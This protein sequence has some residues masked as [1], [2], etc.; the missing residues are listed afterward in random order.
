MLLFFYPQKTATISRKCW[1]YLAVGRSVQ[2]EFENQR[3]SSYQVNIVWKICKSAEFWNLQRN[4]YVFFRNKIPVAFYLI[5]SVSIRFAIHPS[6]FER[7]KNYRA[8]M[9]AMDNLGP[10]EFWSSDRLL[11][12]RNC[13]VSFF[14]KIHGVVLTIVLIFS[15]WCVCGLLF[16][17]CWKKCEEWFQ[18]LGLWLK[19]RL[20]DKTTQKL[21]AASITWLTLSTYDTQGDVH[22]FAQLY[23]F[24]VNPSIICKPTNH[25]LLKLLFSKKNVVL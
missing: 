25:I 20:S 5:F 4:G 19:L 3:M 13:W 22:V 10:M 21:R 23:D 7:S 11:F 1:P 8:A 16:D 14:S 15:K 24:S 17:Y 2:A 6:S 18:W 9:V 12:Y